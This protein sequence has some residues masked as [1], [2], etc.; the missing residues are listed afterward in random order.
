[1]IQFP[2]KSNTCAPAVLIPL[3]Y[4]PVSAGIIGSFL[5]GCNPL[6]AGSIHKMD[7]FLN[8]LFSCFF[9]KAAAAAR[10]AGAQIFLTANHNISTVASAFPISSYSIPC[11][12]QHRQTPKLLPSQILCCLFRCLSAVAATAFRMSVFQMTAVHNG[13]SAALALANP[14]GISSVFLLRWPDYCQH[15]KLL[16]CQINFSHL[17]RL[18]G[19]LSIRPS[20]KT[21]GRR[22]ITI[23]DP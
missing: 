10:T 3:V 22:L 23:F 8:I 5:P 14:A 11:G 1:M 7:R 4:S 19:P 21:G 17:F 12:P 18:A 13:L 6:N 2:L 15:S 9:L 20:Y 16:A